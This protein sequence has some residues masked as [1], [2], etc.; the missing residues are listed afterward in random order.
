MAVVDHGPG[1]PTPDLN[2]IF[3]RFERATSIRNYGGLGLGLY[4]IRAIVDAHGGSVTAENVAE[5]GA[6]FEVTLP[7]RTS[8]EVEDPSTAADFN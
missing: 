1:I 6:R 5:G 8:A 3:E 4:L 2:R 7:L